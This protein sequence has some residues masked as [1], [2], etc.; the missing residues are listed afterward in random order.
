LRVETLSREF[1]SFLSTV[2]RNLEG[3]TLAYHAARPIRDQAH[4]IPANR[5]KSRGRAFHDLT[6]LLCRVG[7]LARDPSRA[8]PEVCE[9]IRA[10][11]AWAAQSRVQPGSVAAAALAECKRLI[12]ET[13][14]L[15]EAIG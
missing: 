5:S 6:D 1:Y 3:F 4:R 2:Q 13:P 9:T 11:L 10:T 15:R 7:E 12:E 14:H 8:T